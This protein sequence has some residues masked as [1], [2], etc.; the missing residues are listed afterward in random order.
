MW[1]YLKERRIGAV[2][3]TKADEDPDPAFDRAASRERNA[4]EQLINRLKQW[5]RI[6]THDEKRAATDLALLTIA[7]ILLWW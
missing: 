1:R 7:C 6:A 5:R 3:S 2:I 4:I